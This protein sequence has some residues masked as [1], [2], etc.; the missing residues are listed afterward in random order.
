MVVREWLGDDCDLKTALEDLA[1]LDE[2]IH[3]KRNLVREGGN[4]WKRAA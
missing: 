3:G 1:E 4:Y 2:A